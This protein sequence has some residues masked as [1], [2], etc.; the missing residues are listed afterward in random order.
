MYTMQTIV[1]RSSMLMAGLFFTLLSGCQPTGTA[2]HSKSTQS[3]PQLF[4]ATK[5]G[6]SGFIDDT[7]ELA[8]GFQ[9]DVVSDFSEGFARVCIG[10]CA[11]VKDN[12][13]EEFSMDQTFQGKYG[14]ID[15]HGKMV[16]APRFSLVGDFHDGLAMATTATWTLSRN[17]NFKY[18]FIDRSGSFVI[19]EQFDTV[20][21]FDP[22]D[23]LAVACLGSGNDSRCGFIDTKGRF[24]INPQFY[25]ANEFKG[26]LA[27]VTEKKGMTSSYIN[28]SGQ[29]VWHGEADQAMK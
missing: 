28:K 19:A 26:S 29:I 24:I 3:E 20:H 25:L 4:R 11:F 17:S 22:L 16:I 18:G 15:S 8:I 12:P 2:E 9:F 23:H 5:G 27:E 7:G 10:T 6:K 13:K 14:F 21:D 1:K